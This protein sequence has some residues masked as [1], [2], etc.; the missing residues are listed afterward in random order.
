V[1]F[2]EYIAR[3]SVATVI[4]ITWVVLRRYLKRRRR[5]DGILRRLGVEP[6]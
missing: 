1:T 4:L 5:H 2:L 6:E 3:L